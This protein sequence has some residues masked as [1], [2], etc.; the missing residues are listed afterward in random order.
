MMQ[1]LYQ[2]P[3]TVG[4]PGNIT[5]TWHYLLGACGLILIFVCK[6]KILKN[7]ENLKNKH[8]KFSHVGY[9]ALRIHT[10]LTVVKLHKVF[11]LFDRVTYS[12]SWKPAG[13]TFRLSRRWFVTHLTRITSFGRFKSS[14]TT[15][16]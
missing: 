13:S 16:W 5:V 4:W 12:G 2:G 14:T 3:T 6:K 11:K 15:W 10:A 7:A 1:V 9:Q 8:T